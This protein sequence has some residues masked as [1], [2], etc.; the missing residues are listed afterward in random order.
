MAWFGIIGGH[1]RSLNIA[2]F[3][4]AHTS[5]LAF[6]GNY[7][8]IL[9]RFWD[10]ARY[11]YWSKI[12]D[13][14]LPHLICRPVGSDPLEFRK[15]LWHQKTAFSYGVV[16]MIL[17]SAILVYNTGVRRTDDSIYHASIASRGKK[18]HSF[19]SLISHNCKCRFKQTKSVHC[20]GHY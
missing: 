9:H 19:K 7:V 20:W 5:S 15:D 16:W 3:D 2:Q 17:R 10:L 18:N 11:W 13:C 1:S 4:R 12:A 8:S 6:Y 14:N